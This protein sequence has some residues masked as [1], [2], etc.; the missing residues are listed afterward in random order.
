[1]YRASPAAFSRPHDPAGKRGAGF[2][3]LL[4]KARMK[5]PSRV[6]E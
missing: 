2:A 6:E 5:H 1:M 3:H 4:A